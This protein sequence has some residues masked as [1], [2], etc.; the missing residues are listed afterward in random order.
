MVKFFFEVISGRKGGTRTVNYFAKFQLF[1][2][3]GLYQKQYMPE[4]SFNV[5]SFL[6]NLTNN[7]KIYNFF[8][9][10]LNSVQVGD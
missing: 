7:H 6:Y 9:F 10:F 8:V 4:S 1:T 2:T 5:F 3:Y